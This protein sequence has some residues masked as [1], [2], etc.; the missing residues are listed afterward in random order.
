MR[1]NKSPTPNV[2][3]AITHHFLPDFIPTMSSSPPIPNG[4]VSCDSMRPLALGC[5]PKRCR[6]E[7]TYAWIREV[8]AIEAARG[9]DIVIFDFTP[10]S[11]FSVALIFGKLALKLSDC[12]IN[13]RGVSPRAV[14]Q[15]IR[16]PPSSVLPPVLHN[17][18]RS[19]PE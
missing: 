12:A 8:G 19:C 3:S 13:M 4:F 15:S 5:L 18:P 2:I 14:L 9:Q 11:I 1:E 7:M 6:P 16:R 17:R 10:L